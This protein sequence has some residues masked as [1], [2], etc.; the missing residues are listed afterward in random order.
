MT[1][2]TVLCA[3]FR[4]ANSFKIQQLGFPQLTQLY[5]LGYPIKWRV[6]PLFFLSD[7][8]HK[9]LQVLANITRKFAKLLKKIAKFMHHNLLNFGLSLYSIGFG[10]N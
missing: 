4:N 1:P 10:E 9:Y 8:H 2:Y 5:F 6:G 3:E 7:L